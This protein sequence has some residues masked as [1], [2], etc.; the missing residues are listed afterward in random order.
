MSRFKYRQRRNIVNIWRKGITEF[1]GRATKS[2]VTYSCK[3]KGRDREMNSGGGPQNTGRW[4][5]MEE[6]NGKWS[7]TDS[8]LLDR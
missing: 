5:S 2:P 4:N 8:G 1:R 3:T 6:T 7:E